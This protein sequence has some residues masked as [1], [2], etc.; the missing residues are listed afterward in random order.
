MK[1][2]QKQLKQII[3]EEVA[4]V[5]SEGIFDRIKSGLGLG[6]TPKEKPAP[7]PAPKPPAKKPVDIDKLYAKVVMATNDHL[8]GRP[9][10]KT[11]EEAL[12]R[13]R[14]VQS[15]FADA[16]NQLP[17]VYDGE[18]KPKLVNDRQSDALSLIAYALEDYISVAHSSKPVGI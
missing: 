2:T 18:M 10:P 7:K 12:L 16:L 15:L 3:K 1:I 8:N 11:R 6:S 5:A 14:K 13:A 9:Y 17:K 4:V